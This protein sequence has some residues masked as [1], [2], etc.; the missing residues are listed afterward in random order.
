[1]RAPG[2]LERAGERLL[3]DAIGR[4]VDAGRER[5]VLAA[6][7]ELDRQARRAHARDEV[8]EMGERRL[9]RERELLVL[10][11]QHPEQRPDLAER[12]APG[13][14]HGSERQL[15][16]V[17]P[18][19]REPLRGRRLGDHRGQRVADQVVELARD[20][21]ALGGHRAG[22]PGLAVVLGGRRLAR[23]APG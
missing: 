8:G 20:P 6:D 18:R 23:A 21:R 5:R 1:M 9:R 15:G 4:E 19:A 11:A 13:V 3:D 17:G 14:L 22:R 10:A 12:L 16:V 2:R 7:V